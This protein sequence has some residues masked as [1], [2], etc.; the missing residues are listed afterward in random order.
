MKCY[1]YHLKF[2]NKKIGICF[3]IDWDWKGIERTLGMY[4][5]II[6]IYKRNKVLSLKIINK[7]NDII[8]NTL[9]KKENRKLDLRKKENHTILINDFIIEVKKQLQ[10]ELLW[11]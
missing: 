8:H 2:K 6:H 3:A 5:L 7:L 11:D 1:N 4:K 10:I 9:D